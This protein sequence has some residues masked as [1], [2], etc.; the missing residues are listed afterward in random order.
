MARPTL[1]ADRQTFLSALPRK[2]TIGN[3]SLRTELGWRDERYWR[4]HHS[5]VEDGR[6][7]RGRGRGG[8]VGRKARGR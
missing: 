6:I 7:V 4:V 5:L 8:S 1:E 3:I 2:D